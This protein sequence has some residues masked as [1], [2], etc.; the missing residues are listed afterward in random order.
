MTGAYANMDY[1]LFVYGVCL[2]LL[3][4][5][6]CAMG[7]ARTIG[8][9][10]SWLTAFAVL[11]ALNQWV[12]MA[13][14][15]LSE[16]LA[17]GAP[18][19]V[20]ALLS[21]LCLVEFGRRGLWGAQRGLWIPAAAAALG[22]S[23]AL[24]DDLRGVAATVGYAVSLPGCLLAFLALRRRAQ[25]MCGKERLGLHTAGAALLIFGV[26]NIAPPVGVS[27]DPASWLSADA[28]LHDVGLLTQLAPALLMAVAAV[29]L[30]CA[31][32][33]AFWRT[34]FQGVARFSSVL[35]SER[36]IATLFVAVLVGGGVLTSWVG[37][38]EDATRRADLLTQTRIGAM[39][40][41]LGHVLALSG[42]K[43]DL[44]SPPYLRLR[45]QLARIRRARPDCR[46]VYLMRRKGDSVVM[47]A[48]S[49]PESSP[50]YS[51]PG[52][53]YSEGE[54][55]PGVREA[56]WA[57][58]EWTGGPVEDRWG[59]WVSALV[60]LFDPRTGAVVAAFGIDFDARQWQS[61]LW[62]T[63]LLPVSVTLV[64][65]AVLGGTFVLHRRSQESRWRIAA[66]EERLAGALEATSE[67]VW[68]RD[69]VSGRVKVAPRWLAALGYVQ[70]EALMGDDVWRGFVHPD[71]LPKALAA[72]DAHL[73]G[74]TPVFRCEIR[75]RTRTGAYL[76]FARHGKVVQRDP[77]GKPLRMVGADADIS[78]RKRAEE[79]LV[80][81]ERRQRVILDH[82]QAGVFVIDPATRTILEANPA[83]EQLVGASRREIVGNVCHKFVCS[84]DAG[85]CPV[86]DLGQTLDRAERVLVTARGERIPVLKSVRRI[87]LNGK[88][89]L[90]ESFYD[91]REWKRAEETLRRNEDRLQRVNA[92]LL[93]MG[94]D[95]DENVARVT[96]LAGEMLGGD[97]AVYRRLE[98]DVLRARG[99]WN[100]PPL[101]TEDSRPEGR[102]GYDA[103]RMA[104]PG[105]YFVAGLPAS[106]YAETDP[107]VKAYG[108][109]CYMGHPVRCEDKPV[110]TLCVFF[111][112]PYQPTDAD[113][114]LMGL[115]AAA[116]SN[117]ENRR[118]TREAEKT[119]AFRAEFQR[120]LMEMATGLVNVASVDLD[121]AIQSALATIGT[122]AGVDRAYLFHYDFR[123]KVMVNTHEWCAEG[124]PSEMANLQNVECGLLPEWVA[125][126]QRG[127]TVHVPRVAD[128]EPGAPL[129]NI[130]E[131]QG[132]R[133]L[134]TVP[135][136]HGKECLGFVGF[137]AC[138]DEK[139]WDADEIALLRI[140][141][142]L[143]TNAE[144]RRRHEDVVTRARQEAEELNAQLEQALARSNEMTLQAEMANISKS[145]FLANMSHEIR[146]P[147]NGVLGML[148]LLGDTPLDERQKRF[149]RTGRRS[150]EALLQV[151][152]DILD[153]SKIEAGRLDLEAVD[154]DLRATLEDVVETV[155]DK[156][157]A[158]GLELACE[159]HPD[160]PALARGDPGR[161]RQILMNLVSNAVKFTEKGEVVVRAWAEAASDEGM[162]LRCEVRD[163]GI[164]I[165]VEKQDRLFKSFSQ[166]D[167][168]TTRR[169]GG[170]GLGL[171]ISRQ[172]VEMMGGQIGVKSQA[173]QG[174]TFWFTARLDK[175]SGGR[176]TPQ[177][178]PLI[179]TRALV[180][181]DNATNREILSH[182][183]SAWGC[184]CVQAAGGK[185]ALAMMRRAAADGAAFRLAVIDRN[186]PGMDGEELGRRIKEDP[187]LASAALVMLTSMAETPCGAEM[188]A[189]GFAAC[190]SKP[191][192]E[193][194]LYDAIA[195]ALG[196]RE[197]MEEV[198]EESLTIRASSKAGAK[199]LLAEDDE[200]NREVAT[201]A[202]RRAGYVVGYA[203]TGKE[204]VRA[205]LSGEYDL[206]LMDCHMPEM[207]GF[208]A[209]RLI[210]RLELQRNRRMP[211]IALTAN[212]MKGDRERCIESGMDDYLSKPLDIGRLLKMIESRLG[213]TKVTKPVLEYEPFLARCGGDD[214]FA[215][216]MI[217]RFRARLPDDVK[218]IRAAVDAGDAALVAS[219]AHRLKGGAANLSAEPLRALAFEIETLGKE[220][221]TSD[222]PERCARLAQ[223]AADFVAGTA[224]YETAGAAAAPLPA[225]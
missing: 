177:R 134:I 221:R 121:A 110:G 50:D 23:G 111:Q 209:T 122:F 138:K 210:R 95:Y 86:A 19:L 187:Q 49:E 140:L 81:S 46:F 148:S 11:H 57:G 127:E 168:S 118:L 132:I 79:A 73:S 139:T 2:L 28:L 195:V 75:L 15:S 37:S 158:K 193:A 185:D 160:I 123:R 97:F 143:F 78:E 60:P 20:L 206:T 91:I 217:C 145:A 214:A 16:R 142:E 31:Y 162:L 69:F 13:E 171:A 201:E 106:R 149:V 59:V 165:P 173:G 202:L 44:R 102:V 153:F 215:A 72:L 87:E 133:S 101:L 5:A 36:V 117:E 33:A 8:M 55:D 24:L 7:R 174:A 135:L 41:D 220:N 128:L 83:A 120:V 61:R 34:H 80:E 181:D 96:A 205:V 105:P 14:L 141:A 157:R 1:A 98:D 56:L 196:Q 115:L 54:T 40:L 62:A 169:F 163:T 65:L 144:M 207:D 74:Q 108:L 179:G 188:R 45:E 63:R 53:T 184:M 4:G 35:S 204:A 147:M 208:T 156:A 198:E 113:R 29:G 130:L 223:V 26:F 167:S 218:A 225:S 85:Q 126:H 186:M 90:L 68:E 219:L 17:L 224:S 21:Y 100:A 94:P 51:P 77:T 103:I 42:S 48:D 109:Q 38:E 170:T 30:G 182:Y 47:L 152:N 166:V 212:A 119:L 191:V 10:W 64:F 150:A 172:L 32:E 66:S 76:H 43:A 197:Q 176:A 82:I 84:A 3:G 211:I 180:V 9:P 52:Q 18:R 155:A 27:F 199:I 112:R 6:S 178:A 146:T 25:D 203:A 129:R 200:I 104:Q 88:P 136:V 93:S 161:V 22:A 164:G 213:D 99:Q 12:G 194:R 159:V 71:D 70:Q 114:K 151:I 154:F 175:A 124:V 131:S 192:R 190:L 116:L 89:L 39:S 107:S 216:K 67:G 183:L 92:C 125:A 137:D 222:L 58:R 189:A